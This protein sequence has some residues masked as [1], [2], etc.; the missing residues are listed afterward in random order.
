ME[1]NGEFVIGSGFTGNKKQE[2]MDVH[3]ST[4]GQFQRRKHILKPS[5]N[6]VQQQSNSSLL[7]VHQTMD[8]NK[9]S[10]DGHHILMD[11][12][13]KTNSITQVIDDH[14]YRLYFT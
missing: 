2:L 12:P 1:F 11:G 5:N 13:P 9:K 14:P 4:P 7:T 8:S 6:Y 10:I 3:Y